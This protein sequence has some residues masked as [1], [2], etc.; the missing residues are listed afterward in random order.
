MF[1]CS[2]FVAKTYPHVLS[3]LAFKNSLSELSEILCPRVKS[4]VFIHQIK[5]YKNNFLCWAIF[6]RPTPVT[7]KF[8]QFLYYPTLL[9]TCFFDPGQPLILPFFRIIPR[10]YV[11][12]TISD[13]LFMSD[14]FHSVIDSSLNHMY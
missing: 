4:S 5:H 8:P 6:F 9:C 14:F 7:Q 3:P 12:V 2:V 10:I 1:P 11:I 13:I